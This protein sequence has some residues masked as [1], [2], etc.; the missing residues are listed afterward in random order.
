MA[1]DEQ[2]QGCCA[3]RGCVVVMKVKPWVWSGL[4]RRDVVGEGKQGSKAGRHV[5]RVDK[6]ADRHREISH[7]HSLTRSPTHLLQGSLV[8]LS[9]S[10]SQSFRCPPPPPPHLQF[11]SPSPSPIPISESTRERESRYQIRYI[12]ALWSLQYVAYYRNVVSYYV[13][14]SNART[15]ITKSVH[16]TQ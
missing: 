1:E 10:L 15:K 14:I 13:G 6:Q 2:C 8:S 12:Q 16:T 7:P 3:Y 5:G 4:S 11:T 9:V